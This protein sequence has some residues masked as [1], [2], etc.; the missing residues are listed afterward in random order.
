VRQFL[1]GQRYYQKNFGERSRVFWLPD[2]FGY[3]AQLPQIMQ[4]A[5]CDYFLSQKIVTLCFP[6]VTLT[7]VNKKKNSRGT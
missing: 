1:W 5:G 3:A 4:S 2:T 6:F 7:K